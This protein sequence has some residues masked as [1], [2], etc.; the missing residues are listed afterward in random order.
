MVITLWYHPLELLLDEHVYGPKVDMW[1]YAM[2]CYPRLCPSVC[3][4]SWLLTSGHCSQDSWKHQ[5]VDKN[6]LTV[7]DAPPCEGSVFM[8][9]LQSAT[10]DS[11]NWYILYQCVSNWRCN[12]CSSLLR[13]AIPHDQYIW[14][15]VWK[16]DARSIQ[17]F[18]LIR[19]GTQHSLS[20]Q[21]PNSVR[22]EDE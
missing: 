22:H 2:W 19:R 7:S 4:I 5:L 14:N 9:D 15:E 6:D 17:R 3:Q 16:W 8:A 13:S 12:M 21:F 18:H 11:G 1:R 20:R 10:R